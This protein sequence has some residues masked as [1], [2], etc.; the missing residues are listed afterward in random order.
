MK[1]TFFHSGKIKTMSMEKPDA[2][3]I[4]VSGERILAVGSDNE[5]GSMFKSGHVEKVNL[6]NKRVIPGLIDSH[7][8]FLDYVLG[9][10]D[11]DLAGT[12]SIK[13]VIDLLRQE[14]LKKKPG[15]WIRGINFDHSVFPEKRLPNR[16]DLD[17]IDNPVLIT[18]ICR[19][20]HAAN[21]RALQIA[22]LLDREDL[23][24]GFQRGKHGELNGVILE[25]GLELMCKAMPD[26]LEHPDLISEN[27]DKCL[28]E[29]SGYGLTS[30]NPTS[31]THIG[32]RETISLYQK[33]ENENRLPLRITVHFN[34][35]P[36]ID[37]Q[38][39]LGTSKVRYGG[40][41]LFADGGFSALTAALSFEYK[42]DPGNMGQLNYETEELYS[43]VE[44]AHKRG[45]QV[46]THAL[47]DRAID[48]MLDVLERVSRAY[49]HI[50]TRHRLIHCYVVR[51]DQLER[52]RNLNVIADIQPVFL[53]D[54][55]DIAE[56][57]L[58]EK[59]TPLSYA[60][61]TLIENGITAAGS[62]DCSAALP[63]PW[64]GIDGAVNRVRRIERTPRGGWHPEQKLT[65]DETFRLFTRNS[66]IAIGA[67][68]NVG[69]LEP[70]KLAD[71]VIL[72]DD[73]WEIDPEELRNVRVKQT[74]CGGECVYSTE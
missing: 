56:E 23:P 27:L 4:L 9:K 16:F 17:E 21:T 3:A 48:Q 59:F 11:V 66:S 57:R 28:K 14:S 22:G 44:Q 1:L 53:A 24:A 72:E 13:D 34:E 12:G 19:H 50:K 67:Q 70:G 36:N 41:K 64:M 68:N 35:L 38:S 30:I 5:L 43:I 74:F 47:G 6:E 58:P 60:W 52:M 26:P 10:D 55:V 8:H 69:T 49:P 54:E 71:F 33:L 39:F 63:D 2:E 51:P 73:P 18:R 7:L 65:I 61:K 25:A 32:V 42:N 62:S 20:A 45:I 31:A 29:F 46:A 15:T 40:L 37:I